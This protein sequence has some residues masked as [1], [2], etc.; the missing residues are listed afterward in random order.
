M[1][2]LKTSQEVIQATGVAGLADYYDVIPL[3][4]A[5]GFTVKRR[6]PLGSVAAQV[7]KP[8]GAPASACFIAIAV[9]PPQ[10]PTASVEWE[11]RPGS[12]TSPEGDEPPS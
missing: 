12:T 1:P 8:N 9:E 10:N 11:A 3:L 4:D 7:V 5:A 2:A 6:Y